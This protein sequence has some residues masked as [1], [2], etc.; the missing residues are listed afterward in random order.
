M[1]GGPL[2]QSCERRLPR[3]HHGPTGRPGLMGGAC[4]WKPEELIT[5]QS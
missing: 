3:V 1:A 5:E 4:V 2:W